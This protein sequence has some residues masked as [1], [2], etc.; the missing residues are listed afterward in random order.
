VGIIL[1]MATDGERTL[2]EVKQELKE[3]IGEVLQDVN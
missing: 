2:E 1:A 3:Y